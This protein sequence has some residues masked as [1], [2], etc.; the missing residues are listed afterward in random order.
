MWSGRS[1][2][3]LPDKYSMPYFFFFRKFCESF[4]V[5]VVQVPETSAWNLR[6]GIGNIGGEIRRAIITIEDF[7]GGVLPG[8]GESIICADEFKGGAGGETG[9]GG[10]VVK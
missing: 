1:V 6:V 4:F 10:T 9:E 8:A 5:F 3:F 2:E 7:T